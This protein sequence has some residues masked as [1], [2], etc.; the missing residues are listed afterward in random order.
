[1]R[2][3]GKDNSE[4]NDFGEK[5]DLGRDTEWNAVNK[6]ETCQGRFVKR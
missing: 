5:I 3:E 2:V 6:H 4:V 1:M